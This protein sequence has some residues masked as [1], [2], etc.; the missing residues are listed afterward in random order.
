MDKQDI[1]NSSN[2]RGENEEPL[3]LTRSSKVIGTDVKSLDGDVLGS[4]DD[5]VVD[6]SRGDFS[7][8]VISTGGFLGLGEKLI[9]IPW[10]I[11][12]FDEEDKSFTLTV[13]HDALENTDSISAE[14]WALMESEKWTHDFRTHFMSTWGSLS[15]M[16]SNMKEQKAFSNALMEAKSRT[17][18]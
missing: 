14:S 2:I 9:S 4:I 18:P 8:A 11:I 12:S 6:I 15:P 1:D 5:V 7:Y 3:K 16:V 17:L 13:H 10:D